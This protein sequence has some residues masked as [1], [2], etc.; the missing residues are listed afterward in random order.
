VHRFLRKSFVAGTFATAALA[1]TGSTAFAFECYNASRSDQG[2]AS[3]AKSQALASPADFLSGELGL[4]EAG[5]EHVLT[6]LNEAGFETDILINTH[7]LMAGGLEGTDKGEELLHNGKGIDH[8]GAE[9]FE[10]VE[11]LIEEAFGL[12]AAP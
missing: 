11:P 7:A 12:C 6:G 9:F 1:I 8:L 2:N 10:A 3:A 5:V 4:C